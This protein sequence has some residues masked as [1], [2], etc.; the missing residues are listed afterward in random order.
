MLSR[1]SASEP[2]TGITQAR[3]RRMTPQPH[4][5]RSPA[6]T[7]RAQPA[8]WRVASEHS[9]RA[10]ARHGAGNCVCSRRAEACHDRYD[11][12]TT[13]PSKVRRRRRAG[14]DGP[15]QLTPSGVMPPVSSGGGLLVYPPRPAAARPAVTRGR[16]H[17]W[18]S[19]Y[20]WHTRRAHRRAGRAQFSCASLAPREFMLV[21]MTALISADDRLPPISPTPWPPRRAGHRR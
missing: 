4:L 3:V 6:L 15:V 13:D 12:Q 20:P 11:A 2:I 8:P 18:R 14:H 21:R 1:S 5:P 17:D 7:T 9:D 16:I 10:D 19:T